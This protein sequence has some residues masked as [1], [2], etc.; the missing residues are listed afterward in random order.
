MMKDDNTTYC[1]LWHNRLGEDKIQD[2]LTKFYKLW[3]NRLGNDKF[4]TFSNRRSVIDA[5]DRNGFEEFCELWYTKLGD[6]FVTFMTDGI[7]A[8]F[9]KDGFQLF[10]ELSHGNATHNNATSG[11]DEFITYMTS[12]IISEI[13]KDSDEMDTY[14]R[15]RR[16]YIRDKIKKNKILKTN[17]A[18]FKIYMI[19]ASIAELILIDSFLNRDIQKY[20]LWRSKLVNFHLEIIDIL[21]DDNEDLKMYFDET[22][23]GNRDGEACTAE[24]AFKMFCDTCKGD[25][26]M[27]EAY[28]KFCEN[29]EGVAGRLR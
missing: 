2:T 27:Y 19:R 28:E 3:Y 8:A 21:M 16:A 24:Y 17:N 5:L 22:T 29:W 23:E 6:K 9:D 12:G 4:D 7:A 1:K 13:L 20:K 15:K 10:C 11:D 25:K 14:M 18:E 26:E